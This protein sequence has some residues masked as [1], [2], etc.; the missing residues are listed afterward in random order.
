MSLSKRWQVGSKCKHESCPDRINNQY[1][2][3]CGCWIDPDVDPCDRCQ[4]D[5]GPCMLFR[6]DKP[7]EFPCPIGRC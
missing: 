6:D 4:A 1:G 7:D 3:C 2:E 5:N